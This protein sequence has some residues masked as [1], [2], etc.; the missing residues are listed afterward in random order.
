MRGSLNEGQQRAATRPTP[1]S[2]GEPFA[3]DVALSLRAFPAELPTRE[4]FLEAVE[5]HAER[6]LAMRLGGTAAGC[7]GERSLHI[8]TIPAI[9]LNLAEFS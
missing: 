9:P 2:D 7:G 3:L 4:P 6:K 1:V 8:F 5:V